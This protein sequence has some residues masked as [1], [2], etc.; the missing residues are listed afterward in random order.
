VVRSG[1]G[2]PTI[3]SVIIDRM[4]FLPSA[5]YFLRENDLSVPSEQRTMIYW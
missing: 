4:P 5:L 2:R 3:E 1:S